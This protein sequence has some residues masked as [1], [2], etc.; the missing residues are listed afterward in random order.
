M[1]EIVIKEK[2]NQKKNKSVENELN[3]KNRNLSL[4]IYLIPTLNCGMCG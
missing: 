2:K 3:T 1:S 4:S